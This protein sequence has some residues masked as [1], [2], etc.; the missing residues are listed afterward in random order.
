MEQAGDAGQQRQRQ[1]GVAQHAGQQV[2]E[3]VGDAA[4]QDAK[5]LQLL[6]VLELGLELAT[7]VLGPLVFGEIAPVDDNSADGRMMQ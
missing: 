4:G 6:G 5:A 2:V 1:T 7:V 3:V